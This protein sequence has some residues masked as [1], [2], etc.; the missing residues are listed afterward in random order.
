MIRFI[1][2][3]V[4]LGLCCL[5]TAVWGL[6]LE[7][8]QGR[9]EATPIA[10]ANFNAMNV[11]DLPEDIGGIIRND[12][13][14]SGRFSPLSVAELP[15][16][17]PKVGS[18]DLLE[19]LSLGADNIVV[20][21]ITSSGADRYTVEVELLDVYAPD[22]AAGTG[23]N[24]VVWR[25]KF[26]HVPGGRL[27]SLA[28]H[29][30]D[31]IFERLTGIRGA[32][33]TRIA[34]VLVTGEAEGRPARAVHRIEVADMD[35]HRP[36]TL[37]TSPEPIMSP[38]WSPDG[39]FLAFVSFE[40]FRAEVYVME[41]A[42]G[43]RRLVSH[44]RGINGA[45]AWSPDGQKMALVLSKE[46]TPKLYVLDLRSQALQRVSSGASID[47]E[48]SWAPDGRS[49]IFTSNRGGKPQIYRLWLADGR[50]ERL[51]YEGDYNARASFTF[52]GKNVVMVHRQ[53]A[54]AYR[55]ARLN[56]KNNQLTILTEGELNDSPSIAPNGTMVLYGTQVSG[57][58]MLGAVSLDGRVKLRLPAR[59]GSAQ[60]P[61][62]SPYES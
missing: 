38:A 55:I 2:K 58:R 31:V 5:T 15:T 62:W 8:T 17:S 52:D 61:A 29:I 48:P 54:G 11:R 59:E 1:V 51:T 50:V 22:K 12:L 47:T 40:H 33:S 24:T 10:V 27:R 37:F 45:P 43:V 39:R 25:Q 60:E 23:G 14:I 3:G 46:G 49:L 57:R 13:T 7:I 44:A 19:W 6:T 41:V 56:L 28:H 32:F 30:S 53:G 16:E 42:T 9:V 21:Q 34:Y 18:I 4:L 36:R 26:D 35:G 20:G